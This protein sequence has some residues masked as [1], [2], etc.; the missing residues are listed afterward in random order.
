MRSAFE[1]HTGRSRV[2]TPCLL[3]TTKWGEEWPKSGI[4]RK[5]TNKYYYPHAVA[6]VPDYLV[7]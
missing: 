7:E 4:R 1:N 2:L 3:C 6:L 5:K